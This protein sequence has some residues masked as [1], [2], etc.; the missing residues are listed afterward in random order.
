MKK[1]TILV[2]AVVS[3]VLINVGL[4]KVSDHFDRLS[5]VDCASKSEGALL[6]LAPCANCNDDDP[7]NIA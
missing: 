5:K 3:A 4:T 6:A 2:L 1:F 7:T